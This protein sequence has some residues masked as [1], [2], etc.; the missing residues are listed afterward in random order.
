MK[1]SVLFLT[2]VWVAEWVNSKTQKCISV[3]K[4]LPGQFVRGIQR[5]HA[6]TDENGETIFRWVA[7]ISP[8]KR[9]WYRYRSYSPP[10]VGVVG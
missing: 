3:D 2:A 4:L 1:N 7:E 8:D 10:T 9:L 6:G 5:H